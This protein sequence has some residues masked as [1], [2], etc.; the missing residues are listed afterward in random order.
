MAKPPPLMTPRVEMKPPGPTPSPVMHS[1]TFR[2]TKDDLFRMKRTAGVLWC[3]E[4][5]RLSGN[6]V[7][8]RVELDP[9]DTVGAI[10]RKCRAL[11]S[12]SERR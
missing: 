11:M 9:P 1:A 2:P 4:V 3:V 10:E 8:F 6:Q 12:E 5:T 7:V